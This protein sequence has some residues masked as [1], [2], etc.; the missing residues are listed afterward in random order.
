MAESGSQYITLRFRDPALEAEY[1]TDTTAKMVRQYRVVMPAV[2]LLWGALA[3]LD[4]MIGGSA[5]NAA[6]FTKLRLVVGEPILLLVAAF[7][8]S[9]RSWFHRG[10]QAA[11]CAAGL[12]ILG[13]LAL[14]GVAL[15]EPERFDPHWGTMGIM[16][17]IA[18]YSILGVRVVYAVIALA[19]GSAANLL[20]LWVR[21]SHREAVAASVL[22]IVATQLCGAI[23]GYW[24]ERSRRDAFLFGRL[25]D[26]ERSRSDRIL[27]NVLP[28]AIAERLKS[29]ENRIAESFEEATV[30]FGD[31]VG[32]TR[33]SERLP[34]EELVAL[35]D[36]IFTTFDGI[37]E[38]LGLEKIKTIGDAYMVVGGVPVPRADHAQ[39]VATMALEM[40]DAVAARRL[41]DGTSLAM[42][43]G[44][45]TGPVIAGVIGRKKFLYD[46]WGDTVNTAS[47]MESHGVTAGIQVSEACRDR[48]EDAFELSPRG[49]IEIKGKGT[50]RTYLLVCR[51]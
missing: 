41:P 51:K 5:A 29:S 2:A 30:L 45:H 36:G 50:M 6:A 25:L 3:W 34:P 16:L 23:G 39:A 28:A 46:L 7:G 40:R 17:T 44:I 35:L 33:L 19:V 12:A 24:V 37:A 27:R 10:W 42:R 15:P 14:M 4:P 18:G 43:I 1:A 20:L 11:A 22:W 21:W 8:F 26:A 47:R 32:F 49:A 13:T 48:L 38:R 9:P 31:I